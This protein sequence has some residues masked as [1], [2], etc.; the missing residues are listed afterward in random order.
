MMVVDAAERGASFS[1]YYTHQR[2]R[3]PA[4]EAASAAAAWCAFGKPFTMSVEPSKLYSKKPA[5]LRMHLVKRWREAMGLQ[6]VDLV[7]A[8]K[9][10]TCCSPASLQAE[11]QCV[12]CCK[13]GESVV[14]VVGMPKD[15]NYTLLSGGQMEEYLFC[16]RSRCTSSSEHLRT[17]EVVLVCVLAGMQVKS[18]P[19]SLLSREWK[20]K[21]PKLAGVDA[22]EMPRNNH[23]CKHARPLTVTRAPSSKLLVVVKLVG[24]SVKVSFEQAKALLAGLDR[25]WGDAEVQRRD[26]VLSHL[27]T[28][29]ILRAASTGVVPAHCESSFWF[30]ILVSVH[31]TPASVA[32][33]N[34]IVYQYA[35]NGGGMRN[36]LNKN[37]LS[38]GLLC[39]LTSFNS[40]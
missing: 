22:D 19:F 11:L 9:A 18:A 32:Q 34:K 12:T 40:F 35:S 1:L 38:T 29:E 39:C 14:E 7:H 26:K 20:R 6:F 28:P 2:R 25:Y 30:G 27:C 36:A 37:L 5:T 16:L 3:R 17:S 13:K 31:T 24:V 8:V 4:V 33:L 10:A 23:C 21:R 15:F